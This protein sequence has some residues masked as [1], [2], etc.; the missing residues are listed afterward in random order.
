MNQPIGFDTI[1]RTVL[2]TG[3]TGFV[4]HNLVGALLRDGHAVIALTRQPEDAARMFDGKVRC[5]ASMD[6]LDAATPVDVVVNLAGAR[7]L[8]P[9]W[10]AARKEVL[11]QSRIGLTRRVVGWIGRARHKPFLFLSASAIG[12][13]GIQKIGDQ[14]MLDESAPPQPIFM[15]DLCREWEE[16]AGEAAQYGVQVECTRFGL[17]LGKGGALPMMLL[18]IRLGLGGPLAGGR[19]WLSWIHVEDVVRGMA[20]RWQQALKAGGKGGGRGASNFT[21]PES[22]TQADFSRI[23]ARIWHRP[24]FMPTPGWPMRLALGE[25]ADLLLEGQRVVPARLERE[26]FVFRYPTLAEALQSLK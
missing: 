8:G 26:G 13:Y 12:Y 18:P 1:K 23:A 20:H 5:I 21:A 4:G 9:R 15:S 22:V 14:T 16:A 17:V 25:Q 10:T 2:V 3:A 24:A 6:E 11:R 19:Q 7:I